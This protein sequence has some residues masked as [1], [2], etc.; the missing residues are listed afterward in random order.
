MSPARRPTGPAWIDA[1]RL[2][3]ASST[4]ARHL[5]ASAEN[6]DSF[7]TNL[8]AL[9]NPVRREENRQEP[10]IICVADGLGS[11][12]HSAAGASLATALGQTVAEA[13]FADQPW[14]RLSYPDIRILLSQTVRR[15]REAWLAAIVRG[16]SR[17]APRRSSPLRRGPASAAGDFHTTLIVAV[18][19]P[20]WLAVAHIGDGFVVAQG[21]NGKCLLMNRPRRPDQY[22]NTVTALGQPDATAALAVHY[23]HGLRGVAVSTD[24][25]E[26]SVLSWPDPAE[27]HPKDDFFTT[28]FAEVAAGERDSDR[29]LRM[30][31]SPTLRAQ[32]DDDLT[33]VIAARADRDRTP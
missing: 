24:G 21:S 16:P 29:T 6:Q 14:N 9:K 19:R 32:T 13:T 12:R 28:M 22:A 30:L 15:V 5:A 7:L 8:A 26:D 31:R 4:G 10:L 11:K 25:L 17:V 23:D 33:L 2:A 27:P 3:A 18:V 20:P 1:W